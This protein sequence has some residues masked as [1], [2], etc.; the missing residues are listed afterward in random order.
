MQPRIAVCDDY[1]HAA[2]S[3]ADWSAIDAR[4]EVVVFDRPFAGP[5]E[6]A[7]ALR[8]FDAVCLM[9]ERTPFPASLIDA[10][11]RL[12]FIV[13]TGPRNSG[14]DQQAAARCGIP[15]SS[16]P[17]GPSKASTAEQTWALILAAAKRV[18][19]ADTGTRAGHWRA[20]AAG[21]SYALPANLEGE[22][23]GVVGLGHIGERVARVG[24]AFG[25]EVLA[26]S[27]NLDDERA[28]TVGVRRVSKEE[29]FDTAGVVS[30]HLVLSDRSRG[31]VGAGELA[32]MRTD[33]I[34]VNTSR[35]GLIDQSALLDALR[36]GR[37][38]HAAFDVF[39]REPL[40]PGHP[41]PGLP[42]ITI[43]PHLGYVNAK[44]FAAFHQ[45]IV[46]ALGAWL[47]GAP[48]RVM[49]ADALAR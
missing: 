43:S 39:D 35:A 48:I 7:G 37:P 17:G 38:G 16:T 26:W 20:D 25:M 40:P 19:A 42:N 2:L 32:R 4:A 12:K 11:P 27:P 3:G 21:V 9:R 18:V 10:L 41:L 36:A 45:G 29:L 30:L 23:L 33:A 24:L 44:V 22:R 46:E 34:L 6:A 8:Q 47:D 1:E 49:N 13:F 5:A 15:V 28:A 14:V 31:I